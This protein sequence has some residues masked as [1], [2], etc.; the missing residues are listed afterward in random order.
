MEA[1]Y[2]VT[3][4][5]RKGW[6]VKCSCGFRPPLFATREEALAAAAAHF[7]AEE[8]VEEEPKGF[9]ARR[10]ARKEQRPDWMERRRR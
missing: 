8:P 1:P 7:E 2:L 6:S 9:F 4:T 3:D 10:R 5:N